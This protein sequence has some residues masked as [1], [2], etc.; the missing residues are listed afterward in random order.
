MM[1]LPRMVDEVRDEK[2]VKFK[3]L[4]NKEM[5]YVTESGFEFPVPLSETEGAEFLAED[6]ALYF[7]RWIGRHIKDL[8]E[9]LNES[10][11]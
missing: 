11:K 8:Q 4:K 7:S 5:W 10:L 3:C 6:K 9:A 1:I 2:K